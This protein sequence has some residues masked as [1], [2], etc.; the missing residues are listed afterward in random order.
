MVATYHACLALLLAKG[1]NAED[2][3]RLPKDC[4]KAFHL[5][6]TARGRKELALYIGKSI[7]EVDWH[8]FDLQVEAIQTHRVG[9]ITFRDPGY[10][11]YF[12]DIPKSPP[13]V[14]YKGDPVHLSRR[15]IAV[16]GSRNAS[17]SGCRFA[18]EL[19]GDLAASGVMVAS[20]VARGIDAAAHRGALGYGGTTIGVIGTGIDVVYPR[21]N[22]R[23]LRTIAREGCLVTEQLM[24]TPPQAFVF[25]LRNRLISALSHMVI[26]V[27]A[28]ERSGALVTAKWALE[29]GRDVGAVPGFPRDPRSRG[30]NRLLKMGAVPIESVQDVFDAVPLVVPDLP[31]EVAVQDG[32]TGDGSRPPAALTGLAF[33][34]FQALGD[35]PSDAD[36][37][38]R[39]LECPVVDVQRTLLD[40]EVNGLIARN[41]VGAY[42]KR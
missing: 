15:G 12:R 16:V 14:F 2:C 22:A 34:V 21:E 31:H 25:P 17:V 20:G 41:A 18:A 28:A 11:S 33:D 24:G 19:A 23:L 1:S 39:C 7:G 27:E 37:L 32:G 6:K 26:V 8:R 35:V 3:F 40:L 10:P 42:Y 5:L 29:Q 38:A 9:V 13:I 36:E 4:D 30:V